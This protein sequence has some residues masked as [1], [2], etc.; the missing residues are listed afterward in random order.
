MTF[1]GQAGSDDVGPVVPG[2]ESGLY[3]GGRG[4]PLGSFQRA[5]K[6]ELGF[7]RIPLRAAWEVRKEARRA[8]LRVFLESRQV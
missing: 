6:S 4:K 5:N 7:R 2:K 8:A 1:K 3:S